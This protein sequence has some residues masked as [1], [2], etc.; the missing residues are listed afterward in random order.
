MSGSWKA[1][2]NFIQD[3][4]RVDANVSGRPDR[5]LSD[6]TAYLKDRIDAIDNGQALFAFDVAVDSSV[7]IGQAVYWNKA[8]QQFEKALSSVVT[9]NHGNLVNA[10]QAE[11]LGVVFSKTS[12]TI[13]TLVI[14]GKVQLDL[15]NAI[16]GSVVSGKYFLSGTT[17]GNLTTQTEGAGIPV[18]YADG[19]GIVFVEL[20]H[21]NIAESHCHFKFDLYTSVAGV[22]NIPASGQK[23]TITNPDASLPGWLPADNAV[24][25]GLAPKGAAFG[26]NLSQHSALSRVW[27]PLPIEYASMVLF[28]GD[29]GLGQE[30]PTGETNLAVIDRNGIWWMSDCYGDVPWDINY[31]TSFSSS[32]QS[33][34]DTPE[35][36]RDTTRK[37][38]LYFAKV[39]YGGNATVVSSLRTDS[40]SSPLVIT[41]LDG[42]PSNTGDLKI[43]F[44]GGL[45][46]EN[47][48]A[49][50]SL[51][52]KEFS[53]NKF[54]RGRVIEGIKA[55]NNSVVL[56]STSSRLEGTETVHQG[57]VSIE[58]NLDGVNRLI[59]PQI[60]RLIDVRERYENE[61]P[62]LGFPSSI[63]AAIRY[64]FKLPGADGF[65][66]AGRLKLRLWV[67]GD[68]ATS[69]LPKF[70]VSYRRLPRVTS[71]TAIPTSDT[72]VSWDSSFLTGGTFGTVGVDQYIEV[73]TETFSVAESDAVFF[74]VTRNLTSDD[75]YGGEIGILDA[76]AVLSPGS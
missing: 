14:S 63:K 44:D 34:G 24:F 21:K 58:A 53:S 71:S 18:L 61:I 12:A 41:D 33:Q 10:D 31:T 60:V 23:H 1:N 50:G 5:A 72:I 7:L 46:V 35:C 55:S 70:D 42:N 26:Y 52:F 27:P 15:T 8:N 6:R 38:V 16:S 65:P 39:R 64:K 13:A 45:M 9:D 11:V 69:A 32:E 19:N 67:T 22:H 59:V 62:Y 3:G 4:E 51:V 56:T 17:A 30:I 20:Q 66:V 73:D 2:I 25:N 49:T 47:D 43:R 74:T 48:T 54:R 57:I 29:Q 40:S 75:G 68:V 28:S 36:P 37:L 76:V